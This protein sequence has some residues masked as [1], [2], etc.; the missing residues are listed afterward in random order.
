LTLLG[1]DR[2][3]RER[4]RAFLAR[5]T[6]ATYREGLDILCHDAEGT[7]FL[8]RFTDPTFLTNESL[9]LAIGQQPW[10]RSGRCL[11]LC[12]GTGHL[13]RVLA[14]LRPAGATI[15]ADLYF[16]KLWLAT[17]FMVPACE[18]VCCDANAPLPFA[19]ESFSLVSLSDAFPYI[20]N[21]RLLAEEMMRATTA[22]GVIVMPHLH[23]ALGEN[24]SAGNTLTPSA[25]RDLFAPQHPRLFSDRRLFSDAIE[26]RVVDLGH[27][28]AASD[29]GDEPSLTLVA[30]HRSDLFRSYELP[31]MEPVSG[32]LTVNP[33]YRVERRGGSSILTL[34]FPT[35]EYEQEFGE[36]RRYLPDTV[37]V[38]ADLGGAI[39]PA[40]L[41]SR[42]EELRRRRVVI[43]APP[44]YC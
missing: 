12:G 36:C 34:T 18:P 32:E 13:T 22:D 28:R 8:Y 24:F 42:C 33:L 43:D 41:G 39:D 25:Y 19:R 15:L 9:V 35:V 30:S 16:W 20:W 27:D 1:V 5:G 31:E 6:H 21:K 2:T 17:R 14:R 29:L 26:R 3:R 10:A 40:T 23:S 11:D 44:H 37:T 7:C 4:F 38:D